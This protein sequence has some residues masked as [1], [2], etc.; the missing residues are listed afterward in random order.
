MFSRNPNCLGIS[1][2]SCIKE[3]YYLVKVLIL[4]NQGAHSAK[5]GIHAVGP[6]IVISIRHILVGTRNAGLTL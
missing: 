4:F 1:N 5:V 2:Y 6:C 3:E